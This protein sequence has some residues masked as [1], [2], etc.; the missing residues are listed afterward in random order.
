[1]PEREPTTVAI[2]IRDGGELLRRTLEALAGQT[3]KHELL[4]CDSGSTDG[5]VAA[6]RAHGA[7]V[8][9]IA[10]SQFIHGRARNLLM[11]QAQGARVALLTQDSEPADE[12]W[13]ERLLGGFDLAP[14]VGIV[15]GPY[16]PR[17]EASPAVRLELERWFR[18]LAS[19]G[20][21][22]VD[23]LSEEERSPRP[24]ERGLPGGEL[25]GA[26]GL[27]HG[28]QCMRLPRGV[29]EG[30]VP[31]GSLCR[32]QGACDRHASRRLREGVRAGCGCVALP[33]LHEH[34]AAAPLLRR[35]AGP[36]RGVRLARARLSRVP[37]AAAAGSTGP[38]AS[39]ADQRRRLRREPPGDAH[40]GESSPLFAS[41]VPC[42]APALTSCRQARGADCHSRGGR[43]F[44]PA[45]RASAIHRRH[46]S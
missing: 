23:R 14:D 20:Y 25:I 40:R 34:P 1:M 38:G 6:V 17:P 39:R 28:R 4:V 44:A 30:S 22:R 13:L 18:S 31:R 10:P 24:I 33:R 42:S 12:H 36:A 11:T 26:R 35:V 45:R 7:R 27:L 5:S 15:Y 3:V 8:V 19:D 2:P 46:F 37:G 16:I 21:P 29:V 32:G 43:A 9:E 41:P